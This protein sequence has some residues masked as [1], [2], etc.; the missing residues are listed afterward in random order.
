MKRIMCYRL[1]ADGV[2]NSSHGFNQIT[3][4]HFMDV[5]DNL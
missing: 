5:W 3:R 1:T 4:H 2:G